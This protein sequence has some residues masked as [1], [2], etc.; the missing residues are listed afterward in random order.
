MAEPDVLDD[1]DD[2]KYLASGPG[3]RRR[4]AGPVLDAYADGPIDRH[5]DNCGAQPL[6]FCRHDNGTTRKIPCPTR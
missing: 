3:R 1:D 5:C 2:L 6:Q 4:S